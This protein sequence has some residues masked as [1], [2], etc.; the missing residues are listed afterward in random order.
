MTTYDEDITR[1]LNW[2]DNQAPNITSLINQKQDWYNQQHHN[3]WDQ[4]TKDVFDINTA[5]PFG[6]SIWCNILGV[7]TRLFN[8]ESRDKAFAFGKERENFKSMGPITN[9]R[10]YSEGLNQ[11][12]IATSSVGALAP[13][14]SP[15][16]GIDLVTYPDTAVT[17]GSDMAVKT[18]E[19]YVVSW[20]VKLGVMSALT[21]QLRVS[22][23]SSSPYSASF[24][25]KSDGAFEQYGSDQTAYVELGKQQPYSDMLRVWVKVKI[26]GPSVDIL[27][28]YLS[29]GANVANQTLGGFQVQ[30][31]GTMTPYIKTSGAPVTVTPANP[32]TGGNFAGA[33]AGLTDIDDVRRMLKLRYATLVSNGRISYINRMLNWIFNDGK[34]WNI[35]N[36]EYAYLADKSCS[37]FELEPTIYRA[38]WQG[39]FEVQQ[40]VARANYMSFNKKLQGN[41][42]V[43]PSPA[44]I[45]GSQLLSPDGETN[46]DTFLIGTVA[47][48][49]YI[50]IIS[51]DQSPLDQNA[52][53]FSLS[54]FVRRAG[55]GYSSVIRVDSFEIVNGKEVLAASHTF[56]L[57]TFAVTGTG[58]ASIKN[59][60]LPSPR[61]DWC[62]IG[63]CFPKTV[64]TTQVRNRIY[65][66]SNGGDILTGGDA[67]T[68][69]SIWGQQLEQTYRPGDFIPSTIYGV[70]K[71]A[72]V[73][74]DKSTG[75]FTLPVPP[76]NGATITWSGPWK[77]GVA[78]RDAVGTGDGSKTQFTIPAPLNNGAAVT[79]DYYN[80]IRIGKNVDLS[81]AFIALLNDRSNG[82]FPQNTGISY[83]IVKES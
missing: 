35:N 65:M 6:L 38:D 39:T 69:Y 55:T 77:F 31:G 10:S 9:L 83:L 63:I 50:D 48:Q 18:D 16:H 72:P 58:Y 47:G 54:F 40:N 7:P 46:A 20:F 17:P 80:E 33:G 64:G 41:A 3:F 12:P 32:S 4:W 26:P 27:R 2:M 5:N 53:N 36:K 14:L 30:K 13:V 66:C 62:R 79:K 24:V 29:G 28:I 57:L 81:V 67:G 56:S 37:G 34:P 1:A 60:A 22:N 51:T 42:A 15:L 61:T 70:T 73:V 76:I 19:E 78:S 45:W 59:M 44:V 49:K 75:K 74:V 52:P 43:T 23:P 8:F 21:I 11:L 71:L 25:V 68:G 82:L